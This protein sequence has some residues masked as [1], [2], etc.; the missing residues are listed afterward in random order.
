MGLFA[1]RLRKKYFCVIIEETGINQIN[2]ITS[3]TQGRIV[4]NIFLV[5]NGFDLHHKFPTG[6]LNFL[7]TMKFLVENYDDTFTTV[8][9]VF[10]NEDL[11]KTDDFIK[12]CYD[13]HSGV[14][15]MTTLPQEKVKDMV[16]RIKDNLWFQYLCNSVNQDIKWIDF[17]KEIT[18]VLK[19]FEGFFKCEKEFISTREGITFSWAMISIDKEDRYI[20]SQFHLFYDLITEDIPRRFRVKKKYVTE[21]VVGSGEY[22]FA[23]DEIVS[24]FI[25]LCV[26]LLMC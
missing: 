12:D 3:I 4:M 8:A 22:Y 17:E 9:H 6:Y 21:N 14:Y 13:Q 15:K 11:Q 7:N 1:K 26:N 18:R 23:S 19:A 16:N 25:N 10:G 5:G 2:I 20:L 24:D